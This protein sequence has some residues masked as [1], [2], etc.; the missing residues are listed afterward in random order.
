MKSFLR[1]LS[2]HKMYTVAEICGFSVAIAFVILVGSFILE[3]NKC[4]QKTKNAD[5]LFLLYENESPVISGVVTDENVRNGILQIN[6]VERL[7]PILKTEGMIGSMFAESGN[8]H[9]DIINALAVGQDYF[10]VFG[11]DLIAGEADSV[12]ESKDNIVVSDEYARRIFGD[13][14]PL[15]MELEISEG[16]STVYSKLEILKTYRIS[17]VYTA[18]EKTVI[19][20]T[21]VIFRYD[22]YADR[23]Y[24]EYSLG[25]PEFVFI[26]LK[27]GFDIKQAE[28]DFANLQLTSTRFN[29][30]TK[31][32]FRLE[33]LRG[34]NHKLSSESEKKFFANLSDYRTFR[35]FLLAC[36]V[37]LIFAILNYIML[38]VAFSRFRL[39]EMATRRLLGT[40]E[41]GVVGRCFAESFLLLGFSF[42][43]GVLIALLLRQPVSNLLELGFKPLSSSGDWM[44]L[45]VLFTITGIF[46]G[47]PTSLSVLRYQPVGVIKGEVRKN[48][49]MILG[50]TIV[51]MQGFVCTAIAAFSACLFL[52]TNRMINFPRGYEPENNIFVE[53]RNWD[54]YKENPVLKEE[55]ESLPCVESVS[56]TTSSPA[57]KYAVHFMS[58]TKGTP[59]YTRNNFLTISGIDCSEEVLDMLGIKVLED[60]HEDSDEMDKLYVFKSSWDRFEAETDS[61]PIYFGGRQVVVAGIIDDIVFGDVNNSSP[62]RTGDFNGFLCEVAPGLLYYNFIK[63][64]GNEME[65]LRDIKKLY[66]DKGVLEAVSIQTLNQQ[67][68]EHYKKE[69]KYQGIMLVFALLSMLL[70]GLGLIVLS[71]YWA[72]IQ[73]RDTAIQKIFGCSRKDVF[74]STVRSFCIPVLIGAIVAVPFA[75]RFAGHWLEQYVVRINN[76]IW[77]YL[78]SVAVVLL[79]V[80]ASV[81]VQ[82]VRLMNTNPAEVLKKE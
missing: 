56:K 40:Q 62:G 25:I 47:L 9:K 73:T 81:S 31:G 51:A 59:Q 19:P 68:E 69:R 75:L 29:K 7:I 79:V 22:D 3:D 15:G 1:F 11:V 70:T 74:S 34:L 26:L 28:T 4:D 46:A 80:I 8:G 77:I 6:S 12:L 36:L 58:M 41:A 60:F 64:K 71:S 27:E 17:G 35:I 38:S 10:K 57:S 24:K 63:V 14:D 50:K 23:L 32:P 45:V 42:T 48:D 39:R 37:I 5:R 76:S 55:L 54:I 52:Q 21:D 65:A 53:M 43:L 82:A 44:L 49:K 13:R 66:A 67:I 72:Q 20:V 30:E 2:N 18:P 61:L 78:F 16:T 33:P